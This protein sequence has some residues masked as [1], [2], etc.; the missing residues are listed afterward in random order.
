MKKV[1]SLLMLGAMS[2]AM[3]QNGSVMATSREVVST[4]PEIQLN[5]RVELERILEFEYANPVAMTLA[6]GTAA[7]TADLETS[8]YT[9][10]L[11]GFSMYARALNGTYTFGDDTYTY[12]KAPA[13][14]FGEHTIPAISGTSSLPSGTTAWGI[15]CKT[16]AAVTCASSNFIGL[17]TSDQLI[18]SRNGTAASGTDIGLTVGATVSNVPAG[19]YRGAIMLTAMMNE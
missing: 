13:L 3:V 10:N 12:T 6:P 4:A 14:E 5:V 9:N 11:K 1:N 18:A 17:T 16:D 15:G 19:T 2:L 7:Q 8:V